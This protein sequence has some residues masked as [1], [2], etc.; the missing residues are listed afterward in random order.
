LRTA[1]L[2]GNGPTLA[3]IGVSS[4]TAGHPTD[5]TLY[6]RYDPV[7]SPVLLQQAPLTEGETLTTWVARSRHVETEAFSPF[8]GPTRHVVPPSATAHTVEMHGSLDAM[9]ATDSF[10]LLTQRDGQQVALGPSPAWMPDAYTGALDPSSTGG[11]PVLYFTAPVVQPP[12]LVDPMATGL[13]VSGGG[14]TASVGFDPAVPSNWFDARGWELVMVP[15]APGSSFGFVTIP[16]TRVVEVHVPQ[17][18]QFDVGLSS[19][20]NAALIDHL[21]ASH[22]LTLRNPLDLGPRQLRIL[23]GANRQVTPPNP[24]LFVHA[25]KVPLTDPSVNGPSTSVTRAA[26][27]TAA[28]FSGT[29]NLHPKSTGR[30]DIGLTWHEP[31]D[32]LGVAP[33][34]HEG[35]ASLPHLQVPYP[36]VGNPTTEAYSGLR[37]EFG[38]TK[39]RK[40][41]MTATATTRYASYFLRS[42]DVTLGASPTTLISGV[43]TGLQERSVRV[44]DTTS[45]RVLEEGTDFVIDYSAGT[46]AAVGTSTPTVRVRFVPTPV[47]TTTVPGAQATV[48]V[49]A[50]APPRVP[51]VA[52]VVPTF[53]DGAWAWYPSPTRRLGKQRTRD[54]RVLRI[55]L[56]RPW[57]TSGEDEVLGVVLA[58]APSKAITIHTGVTVQGLPPNPVP[59]PI[60]QHYTSAWGRDP[61]VMGDAT[62]TA[63]TASNFPLAFA[64]P[65]YGK[66]AQNQSVPGTSLTCIVVPHQVAYD[67]ARKQWFADV[68]IN[69][70]T[71]YRPFVRLALVRFQPYAIAGAHV[72]PVVLVDAAQLSPNR[73]MIVTGAGS[74]RSVTL[75][76]PGYASANRPLNLVPVAARWTKPNAQV[77]VQVQSKPTTGPMASTDPDVGWL[78]VPNRLYD[79]VRS[80]NLASDRSTVFSVSGVNI[81]VPAGSHCRL[82]VREYE[83]E[84]H[85][86]LTTA[87]RRRLVF[88]DT[89]VLH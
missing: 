32:T 3:D 75:R 73:T 37:Q 58:Q 46:I 23:A 5:P 24:L 59:D 18:E 71:A 6:L 12:W 21:A 63:L 35:A 64:S 14:A 27:S 84:S 50:S 53:D 69:L 16:G 1:D 39:H 87:P 57:F 72:S 8:A 25:V 65:I 38:D 11:T 82:L 10:G 28:T 88:A 76:G 48:H 43:E 17:G 89:Y 26:K 30:I 70:G 81:T 56:D 34:T 77:Q 80:G 42:A 22:L 45:T 19:T 85:S 60:G 49:P 54:G 83:V 61:L 44:V 15:A 47:S 74:T 31:I 9:A 68:A 13:R 40:V 51:S 78:D 29:V 41:L 66:W 7:P 52:D 33:T 4:A 36:T 67:T 2:A 79:L 20:P 86:V 62:P 55:Y